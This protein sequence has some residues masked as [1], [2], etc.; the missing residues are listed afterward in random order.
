MMF[1]FLQAD[2]GQSEDFEAAKKKVAMLGCEVSGI[3][4]S[5]SI[6]LE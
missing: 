4:S 1:L 2:V 5:F 6:C 3:V